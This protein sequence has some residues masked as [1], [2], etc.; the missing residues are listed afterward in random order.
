MG[1]LRPFA[2]PQTG[3]LRRLKGRK[4]GFYVARREDFNPLTGSKRSI[5]NSFACQ[6][7]ANHHEDDTKQ[8]LE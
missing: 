2:S 6:N 7:D 1:A 3:I 4:V 8:S 5:L